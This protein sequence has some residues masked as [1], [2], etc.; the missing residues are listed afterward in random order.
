MGTY[1]P[2][3]NIGSNHDWGTHWEPWT[4]EDPTRKSDSCVARN[5]ISNNNFECENFSH[6]LGEIFVDLDVVLDEKLLLV[7]NGVLFFCAIF[8]MCSF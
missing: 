5:Q 6:V 4:S 7:S 2:N 8:L 3:G 1:V